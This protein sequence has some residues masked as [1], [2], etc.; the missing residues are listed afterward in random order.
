VVF[1][2][3]T[4]TLPVLFPMFFITGLLIELNIFK[5]RGVIF[6]SY[7]AGFPTSARMLSLLYQKGE[8]SRREAIHT[9]TYTSTVTPAFVILSLGLSMYHDVFLGIMIFF[10]HIF[11]A[12]CNG[13]LYKKILTSPGAFAP[14]PSLKGEYSIETIKCSPFKKGGGTRS[15]TGDVFAHAVAV[16]LRSSIRG[17]IK[18]GALI[19]VFYLISQ[20]F[21]LLVSSILEMTTGVY[22]AEIL[23]GFWR[24]VIPCAIVSFGGLSVAF[25]GRIFLKTFNLPMWFYFTYKVTQTIFSVAFIMFFLLLRG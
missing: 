9:A 25:Q 17:I 5:R 18:V 22:R 16:S 14:P 24:A 23:S 7:I 10:A 3:L 12:I 8:I 13:I 15:V 2:V 20:P 21:G 6:L 11:G 4:A 19:A 1:K